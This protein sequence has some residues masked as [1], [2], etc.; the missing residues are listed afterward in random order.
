M[1]VLLDTNVVLDAMLQRA[2]WRADAEAI[3][4]A[5]AAGRVSCAVTSLSLATIFY[6]GRKVV[7]TAAARTGIRTYLAAFAVLPIDKQTLLDADALA[8]SDFED[9]I[10]MAAAAIAGLD[11]IVTRNVP[12]FAH[13]PVPAL[14][15]AEFLR[16]LGAAVAGPPTGVP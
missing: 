6:V 13:S 4:K 8:G 5:A 16:R 9:N 11:A 3:L 12:D 14:E 10:T 2:P 15:P 1:R 7:G